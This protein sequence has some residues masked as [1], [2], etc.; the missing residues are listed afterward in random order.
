MEYKTRIS[1]IE[2]NDVTIRGDKLSNLVRAGKFTD[3]IFLE[4]SGRKPTEPESILFEKML[5]SCL[6]HG[7]GTTSSLTSR[8]VASG[9]NSLNVAVG[10]GILSIGNY[11]GGAIEKAME[12]FYSW[13]DKTSEEVTIIVKD[14]ILNKKTL[15]GFGHKHYKDEDPRVSVLT[16]EISELDYDSKFLFI[17]EIVE[18]QFQQIKNKKIPLNIDGM[19]ALLLCDFSFDSKLGKGIFI[20]GRTPGL[21]AQAHEELQHEKPV[22]RI[23]EENIRYVSE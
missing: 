4:L 14:M 5:I 1:K 21:V 10:G 7:M 13:Q 6:D 9:G 3:A 18:S 19:L 16:R 15:Y 22:R 11:H 17:K 8:F 12:L 20:I 23:S 2:N